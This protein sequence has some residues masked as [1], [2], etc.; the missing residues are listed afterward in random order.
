MP[1][2]VTQYQCNKC[3]QIYVN[4]Q[5]AINC[6]NSHYTLDDLTISR[7]GKHRCNSFYPDC[8]YVTNQKT[9]KVAFYKFCHDEA[10]YDTA[11]IKKGE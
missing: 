6:E 8:I 4:E 11:L 7:I 9:N 3:L 10:K 2:Q 1:T 5:G